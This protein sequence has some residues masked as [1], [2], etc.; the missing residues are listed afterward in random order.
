[1][2]SQVTLSPEGSH[3]VAREIGE[4]LDVAVDILLTETLQ[5]SL[6]HAGRFAPVHFSQVRC[7]V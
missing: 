7:S 5:H 6:A 4:R 2:D 3:S 1:V